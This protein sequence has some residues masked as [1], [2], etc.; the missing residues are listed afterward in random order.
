MLLT[1][2]CGGLRAGGHLAAGRPAARVTLV[3]PGRAPPVTTAVFSTDENNHPYIVTVKEATLIVVESGR[4]AAGRGTRHL[5]FARQPRVPVTTLALS[6]DDGHMEHKKVSESVLKDVPFDLAWGTAVVVTAEK[7]TSVARACGYDVPHIPVSANAVFLTIIS[8]S[9]VKA[10]FFTCKYQ[11]LKA[12]LM[13]LE[14]EIEDEAR[15]DT[16]H[17]DNEDKWG[18]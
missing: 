18:A 3:S 7:V 12:K 9:L 15:E 6:G 14:K 4:L 5:A 1:C 11:Y 17:D 10:I 8:V 16:G 2:S 13:R